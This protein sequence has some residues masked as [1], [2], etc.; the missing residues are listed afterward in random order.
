MKVRFHR[1][2]SVP[3]KLRVYLLKKG[4]KLTFL[5]KFLLLVT[6]CLIS[7]ARLAAKVAFLVE[8]ALLG[9]SSFF[10]NRTSILS[11]LNYFM[12]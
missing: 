12:N 11:L 6:F 10:E 4:K 5:M 8:L 9:R 2:N 3:L 1:D 7:G